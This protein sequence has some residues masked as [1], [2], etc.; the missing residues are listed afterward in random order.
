MASMYQDK[1]V[2][3]EGGGSTKVSLGWLCIYFLLN[4][5]MIQNSKLCIR[6][7]TFSAS[8]KCR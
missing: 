8:P 5:T 2:A 4:S 3:A 1:T 6:E 7:G